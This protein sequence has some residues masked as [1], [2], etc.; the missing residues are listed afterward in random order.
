M[1][2]WY[3]LQFGVEPSE[4]FMWSQRQGDWVLNCEELTCWT[5]PPG[6]VS[7]SPWLSAC[8]PRPTVNA[9][10]CWSPR[11]SCCSRNRSTR[12]RWTNSRRGETSRPRCVDSSSPPSS[13]RIKKK[14]REVQKQSQDVSH[15]R[16]NYCASRLLFFLSIIPN[17]TLKT[18]LFAIIQKIKTLN[19]RVQ[20]SQSCKDLSKSTKTL[21]GFSFRVWESDNSSRAGNITVLWWYVELTPTTT[22]FITTPRVHVCLESLSAALQPKAQHCPHVAGSTEGISNYCGH[23]HL[24]TTNKC[25]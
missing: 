15:S 7:D 10:P 18:R 23:F 4:S 12:R 1:F 22:S 19:W 9:S 13:L 24:L 8:P 5:E 21:T 16:L 20:S 2:P 3:F 11:W 25:N 6:V 17:W 14:K